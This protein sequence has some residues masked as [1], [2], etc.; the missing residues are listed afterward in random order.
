MVFLQHQERQNLCFSISSFLVDWKI[1]TR[2]WIESTFKRG[3]TLTYSEEN[4]G[5]VISGSTYLRGCGKTINP[6]ALTLIKGYW[7]KIK[8]TQEFRGVTSCWSIFGAN[9]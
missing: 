2:A 1:V 3:V 5:L 6:G 8:Y 7:T 4:Y 9:W